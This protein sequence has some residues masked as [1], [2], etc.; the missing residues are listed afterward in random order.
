MRKLVLLASLLAAQ[1]AFA[2]TTKPAPSRS[3]QVHQ[4]AHL[5]IARPGNVNVPPFDSPFDMQQGE[6][7]PLPPFQRAQ[8][9]ADIRTEIGDQGLPIFFQGKTA[10]S[11]A[12]AD[13][14]LAAEQALAYFASL[15]PTGLKDVAQEFL[16]TETSADEQGGLHVRLIQLYKG[17]EV[18]GAEVIAHARK[19]SFEM[20]NG[21]YYPTPSLSSVEPKIHAADATWKV[22]EHFGFDKAKTFWTPED[23]KLV[24]YQ[25]YA[26]H[27]VI[28][29][30]Q[31][32]LDS[33]R[34]A[35]MVTAR[36]NVLERWVYFVDAETGEVLHRFDNTCS[37]AGKHTHA[38]AP[39]NSGPV[40]ATGTD[41]LDMPRSF[42]AWDANG[43]I[44][45]EDTGKDM[46]NPNAS[47]MP[48]DPV[49]AIVT[50]DAKNTSPVN[51]G[52]SYTIVKSASTQFTNKAAVSTHYNSI[53]SYDYFRGTFGR[54]SIDGVGGNIVAF[55]N[56]S[57]KDGSSME[58]AFW[59]GD[60][61]WYGNG[62]TAFK[63]LARGL[64]VGGHE[65]THGV[66]EKTANLTYQDESGALNES[67]ADVFGCMI[68]RDDWRMGEDVLQPGISAS[69]ALR[70]LQ[71]PNN[72]APKN[73]PFWQPKH[74]NERYVGSQDNGGVHINSGI[75]NHA[76]YLFASNAAV[77][78]DK[79][80]QVYYKALRDYLVKSSQFVDCRLA[81][82]QAAKDLYGTAVADVA[83]NAFAAVGIGSNQPSGNYQGQLAVNPGKDYLYVVSN[84]YSTLQLATGTGQ[85]LG[86]LYDKGLRS[87]PSVRDNGTEAVFVNDA[88]QVMLVTLTFLANGNIQP[89]V[90]ILENQ[91]IWHNAA[92]SKDG[93][94]VALTTEERDNYILI[95][96][97]VNNASRE[98][99]LYNPT[100]TQGQVTGDVQYSDVMEFDYSGEYLM[101]DA[102]N[103]Y[104]NGQTLSY[105]DI[106]FLQ[107]WENG[108]FADPA[109]FFISKLF[110]G[111]PDNT[112]VGNPAIAK[113]S[114]YIIAFDF[115]DETDAPNVYND[116]YGVNTETGDYGK[117]VT[118]NGTLGWPNF[119]RTDNAILFERASANGALS[120][121][122]QGLAP[123]KIA[124]QG[125]S[126]ALI[127]ERNWGVW[128]A[129][130]NR[131]LQ[132]GTREAY[133]RIFSLN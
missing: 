37:F 61:M 39:P 46:F 7:Q 76:F 34:L 32:K 132:V 88:G 31:R 124:P 116:I 105:W 59:N 67:F 44:Y 123:S 93:R 103:E 1:A 98:Y 125:S 36:P 111:L 60:A 3:S 97:F 49:G 82:I 121:R 55:F 21:R 14:A 4:P 11:A 115:I 20:L 77:G 131:S 122:L 83:A 5:H 100:Y 54:K 41:L 19:G 26:C 113:N 86:T 118:N 107:F 57:E 120:L 56:V 99:R 38:P 81:V 87:R 30:H 52:F 129:N 29:H 65:M 43:T 128:F 45:M 106:G 109:D 13:A 15:S 85:I 64:D 9:P 92:L 27:L 69:G 75:P 104:P 95:Y 16:P 10:A 130:G 50:L 90:D 33:E 40:P 28:Y 117:L 48:N 89:A 91:A 70:S 71:D 63:P 51:S 126:T 119:T 2:Q 42:G 73:T 72:S 133:G 53:R 23:L 47:S 84:D 68:D 66:I 22:I 6:R 25:P 112:S 79:A 94:F 58:N 12:S 110:N 78:K 108:K 74:M 35:W 127:S 80:E 8:R 62:G 17:V 102:Y 18:Y 101:Y 114:P 96:D 24:G